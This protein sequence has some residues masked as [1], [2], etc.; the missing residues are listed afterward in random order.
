MEL[1]NIGFLDVTLIDLVDILLVSFIFYKLY[2]VMRGTVAAQIFVGLVLIIAFSFV[3]QA[4]NFKAMSWMLR[5]LTD[6]W[7]IAFIVLFQPE[8]RRLLVLVGRNRIVRLFLRLDVEESIEE[9]AAA[10]AELTRKHHGMLVVIVRSTGMRTLVETGIQLQA[11][12]SRH[13]L[14]SLFNPRAPLHDGAVIVRDRIIEAARVTLPLSQT[15]LIG[16]QILGM[17]HRSAL[18]ISEQADVVSVVVSQETGMISIADNGV[19]IRGLSPQE[20][21][22]ELRKRL[23]SHEKAATSIWRI[24]RTHG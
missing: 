22:S 8:L 9:I 18:G 5:T 6:I 23:A 24:L 20:L 1:F 16:D 10:A 21:R 14:I 12:I 7:V 11:R 3:A 2:M 4:M 15:S 19:L 17:R 13:L